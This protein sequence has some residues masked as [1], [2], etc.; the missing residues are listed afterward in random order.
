MESDLV[1]IATGGGGSG[2]KTT[3]KNRESGEGES[4]VKA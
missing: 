3:K 1:T 4:R 2:K